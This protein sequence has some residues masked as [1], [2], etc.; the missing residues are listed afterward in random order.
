MPSGPPGAAERLPDWD[1]SCFRAFR[2]WCLWP[3]LA[4]VV[5]FGCLAGLG[6]YWLTGSPLPQW[7]SLA[8]PPYDA[9]FRPAWADGTRHD[10][11]TGGPGGTSEIGRALALGDGFLVA[12]GAV[13]APLVWFGDGTEWSAWDDAAWQARWH[14]AAAGWIYD[15]GAGLAA[16]GSR[17]VV[18]SRARDGR[19][20][21]EAFEVSAADRSIRFTGE[22]ALEPEGR[23][24]QLN[25]LELEG[26]RLVVLAHGCAE[27]PGVTSSWPD[28]STLLVYDLVRPDVPP[29]RV[30]PLGGE[31][32]WWWDATLDGDRLLAA[33]VDRVAF[34][35]L[36]QKPWEP[37][38]VIHL[39]SLDPP[40]MSP[41]RVALSGRDAAV[42]GF[43]ADGT[44]RAET[45]RESGL[46]WT[47]TGGL[48]L[49]QAEWERL[50]F[51]EGRRR[52]GGSRPLLVGGRLI[53]ATDAFSSDSSDS[54]FERGYVGNPLGVLDLGTARLSSFPD[55]RR[56]LSRRPGFG[57]SL[58][59]RH[60][61]L[62]VGVAGD[63]EHSGHI[64]ASGA[65]HVY[66]WPE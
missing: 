49:N 13:H 25:S 65:M 30:E 48:V 42:L 61:H 37:T 32:G 28:R 40:G 39:D 18:A 38:H 47:R 60:G 43:E 56:G 52:W 35:D 53:F 29:E 62:F 10:K 36:G 24:V 54:G 1:D 55:T 8:F 16:S 19:V 3:A 44:S 15:L 4:V 41:G 51:G 21:L 58:R 11:L 64:W 22:L 45:F 66:N 63:H 27:G 34:F 12:A 59:W 17:L 26:D 7:R 14:G 31:T 2:H 23:L 6:L 9:H 50:G 5:G 46:G 57:E 20:S 33:A